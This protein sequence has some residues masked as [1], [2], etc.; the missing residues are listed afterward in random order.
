M[1]AAILAEILGDD[2]SQQGTTFHRYNADYVQEAYYGK[3]MS[4]GKGK[5]GDRKNPVGPCGNPHAAL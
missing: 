4:R 1:L 2:A 3:G 5:S